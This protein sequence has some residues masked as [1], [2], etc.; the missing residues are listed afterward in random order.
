VQGY[1]YGWAIGML[2]R[3]YCTVFYRGG[4]VVKGT[5]GRREKE[6]EVVERGLSETETKHVKV[7]GDRCDTTATGIHTNKMRECCANSSWRVQRK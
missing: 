1:G 4:G 7:R 6:E 3:T 2:F 5:P